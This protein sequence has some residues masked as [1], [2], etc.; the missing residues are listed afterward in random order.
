MKVM[1]ITTPLR[2]IPS[3][4]TPLGALSVINY[5][6]K[7]AD[8]PVEIDFFNIDALRPKYA[9]VIERIGRFSPDIIGISAVVS[10]AYDYTKNISLDIKRMLPESLVV[11]GGNLAASAEVLLRKT[12]TDL[13][14]LGEGEKV[15]LNVVSR[16]RQ[17]RVPADFSDIPGIVLLD[18]YDRIVNTGYE[19]QLPPEEIWDIDW[20]DIERDGTLDL[21]IPVIPW[22][23]KIGKG[24]RRDDKRFQRLQGEK[25]RIAGL[26]CAKGCVAR[27]TFCHRWDKGMRH[28]P[29]EVIMK[30]LE[31]LMNNY[32]VGMVS[33][34][35]E[36]FGSDKRWLDEFL[37]KIQPYNILWRVGGVRTS[38]ADPEI[39]ERMKN[40]GCYSMIYGNETGSKKMLEIMEK[41]VKLEDNYNAAKWT[42]EAGLGNIIQLVIGMPGE[43]PETISETIEYCKYAACYS[44]AQDPRQISINYAQALPGTP[45]YE[46]ARKSGLLK[47]DIESEEEY[48]ISISDKDAA[49][50]I[51]CI[52][53]TDYPRLILL[54][55]N[56]LIRIEVRHHYAT[57]FG[58]QH[59]LQL[60]KNDQ[61]ISRLP[62]DVADEIGKTGRVSVPTFIKL[63][64]RKDAS[65]LAAC[66]TEFFF[67]L[68]K[69]AP[70]FTL[71]NIYKEYGRKAGNEV[72]VDYIKSKFMKR[73]VSWEYEYRSLRKIVDF[74]MAPISSDSP[75][76]VPLRKGR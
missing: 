65:T 22:E 6:R 1:I 4:S 30:R 24:I 17:S 8:F 50:P 64:L 76:M 56:F 53:F 45:L 44:P 62:L 27:C 10:T 68:R 40:A 31:Y 33:T 15:F 73:P 5:L 23:E 13:C 67:A 37:T 66:F 26:T 11:V 29:V 72:F 34:L 60:L 55:W 49:D 21:Y 58:K 14:V 12:G 51:T 43:T 39:I 71:I 63:V 42:A 9:E 61:S 74:D 19:E 70:A 57:K 16:A 52:N 20:S 7:H 59:Y 75:A 69:L 46:F 28:I 54:S 18:K 41:K 25:V 3:S 36:S 32:N 38:M 35:A 47:P 48:L 2:P